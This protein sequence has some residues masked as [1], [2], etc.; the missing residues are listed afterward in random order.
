[1]ITKALLR[2]RYRELQK[3]TNKMIGQYLEGAIKSGAFELPNGEP[4]E[5][6]LA[7]N[8]M[9][10]ALADSI[11]QWAPLSQSDNREVKNIERMTYPNYSTL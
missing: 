7:K 10:A 8:I 5:Y 11:S 4:G 6:R 2:K 3:K 9:C 1:M